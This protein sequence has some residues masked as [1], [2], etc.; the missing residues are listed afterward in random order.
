VHSGSVNVDPSQF[1]AAWRPDPGVL[2][3]PALS[4][5]RV[6]EEVAVRVGIHGQTIRATLFGRISAVRRVGRP[7]LPPG[8]E[9]SLDRASRAAAGF[10]AMASR[11]EPVSFRE[12]APRYA[13]ERKLVVRRADADLEA[14]TINLSEGG[15]SL[16]WQGSM[17]AVGEVMR[18]RIPGGLFPAT[19]RAVVCWIQSGG[20]AERSLG[21]RLVS[22]GRAARR[23][24]A[25][26]AE[27][28]RSGARAA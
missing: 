12:R 10:L 9:V 1:L 27:V 25:L 8:V 17:P 5:A 13:A 26:V 28:A 15:C 4:E 14:V 18:V 22:E 20:S 21:L 6:G 3:V 24:K 16:K 11:G 19:G 23:W 2:F 7:S